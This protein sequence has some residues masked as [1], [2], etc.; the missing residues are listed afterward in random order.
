MALEKFQYE[1]LIAQNK[2]IEALERIG[3][4]KILEEYVIILAKV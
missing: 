2:F 4:F 3:Y 1:S